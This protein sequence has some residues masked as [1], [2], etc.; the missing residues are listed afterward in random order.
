[1]SGQLLQLVHKLVICSTLTF[2]LLRRTFMGAMVPW[3]LPLVEA[4]ALFWAD[5]EPV[6]EMHWISAGFVHDLN[7]PYISAGMQT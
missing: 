6:P 2:V 3:P 5:L 1:M 4:V 7:K